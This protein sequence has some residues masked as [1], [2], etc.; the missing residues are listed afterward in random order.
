MSVDAIRDRGQLARAAEIVAAWRGFAV[1][2]GDII[3]GR[4]Q[5]WRALSRLRAQVEGPPPIGV[6]RTCARLVELA[7]IISVANGWYDHFDEID[8]LKR[9]VLKRCAEAET[10]ID[11]LKGMLEAT[12]R[13]G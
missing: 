3:Q 13:V 9:E 2:A 11:I 12:G 1:H 5:D 4:S 8:R 6:D 7:G 10:G